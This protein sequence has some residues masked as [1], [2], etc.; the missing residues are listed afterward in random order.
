MK[1][2]CPVYLYPLPCSALQ[3]L[4]PGLAPVHY[5]MHSIF[6]LG[7]FIQGFVTTTGFVQ[8]YPF[9]TS[10]CLRFT[11]LELFLKP[12]EVLSSVQAVCFSYMFL[13][14]L[15]IYGAACMLIFTVR[16]G[17]ARRMMYSSKVSFHEKIFT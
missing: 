6:A 13:W 1:R 17:I 9:S 4:F 12:A 16:N 2:C 8:I 3:G 10:V 15:Y 5:L 7:S 14:P 11:V